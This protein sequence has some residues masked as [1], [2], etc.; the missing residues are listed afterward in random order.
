LKSYFRENKIS[1]LAA[2][3]LAS[4]LLAYLVQNTF[5]FDI[6]DSYIIFYLILAFLASLELNKEKTISS[7][8]VLSGYKE[9]I[10]KGLLLYAMVVTAL[11]IYYGDVRPYLASCFARAAILNL[12]S[13][14][15]NAAYRLSERIFDDNTFIAEEAVIALTYSFKEKVYK[16]S[17]TQSKNFFGL[18]WS[19]MEAL[20]ERRPYRLRLY[21]AKNDLL[22]LDD[23]SKSPE[24]FEEVKKADLKMLELAPRFINHMKN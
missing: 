9:K 18:Y 20:M 22:A 24:I 16:M 6:H 21:V 10:I 17:P 14:N 1:F 7:F 12:Q 23:Y 13:E 11:F 15:Y 5:L 19:E 2:A 8:Q 3:I 4:G